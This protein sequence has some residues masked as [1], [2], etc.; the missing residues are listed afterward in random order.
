MLEAIGATIA[1]SSMGISGHLGPSFK[2]SICYM[3]KVKNI[4]SPNQTEPGECGDL[5]ICYCV[6]LLSWNAIP[7]QVSNILQI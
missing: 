3:T 7:F 2:T 1:S 4:C 6:H 5:C